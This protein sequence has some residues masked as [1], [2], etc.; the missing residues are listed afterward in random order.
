M[1]TAV[2]QNV[3]DAPARTMPRRTTD[4]AGVGIWRSMSREVDSASTPTI[5]TPSTQTELDHDQ[6]RTQIWLEHHSAGGETGE[7]YPDQGRHPFGGEQHIADGYSVRQ[8][9]QAVP[10]DCEH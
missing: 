10:I 2:H 9:E 1:M 3:C 6:P 7:P 8:G 4:R 5:P